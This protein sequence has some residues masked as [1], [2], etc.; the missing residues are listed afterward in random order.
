MAKLT[1]DTN[2]LAALLADAK[3]AWAADKTVRTYCG[4]YNEPGFWLVGDEGIYL[5]H[6][7]KTHVRANGTVTGHEKIAVAG[8]QKIAVVY[9]KEC[10]PRKGDTWDSKRRLFGA[11]DGIELITRQSAEAWINSL[12]AHKQATGAINIT[13]DAI[14]IVSAI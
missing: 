1:F 14:T 13:P 4:L 6:N 12:V 3:R 9:A 10:D 11:D 8:D 5:M 2:E 7:G